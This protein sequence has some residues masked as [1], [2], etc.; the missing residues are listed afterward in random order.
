[1]ATGMSLHCLNLSKIHF[2]FRQGSSATIN[3]QTDLSTKLYWLTPSIIR[4]NNNLYGK[5]VIDSNS[6]VFG[7][8]VGF[9]S[10]I[11]SY[12]LSVFLYL[13]YPETLLFI[14][15]HM[16]KVN[17]K[18]LSFVYPLTFVLSKKKMV[19]NYYQYVHERQK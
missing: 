13:L 4:S 15:P 7:M 18:F 14:L 12:D 8:T 17:I 19:R 6:F 10:T 1:M 16:F 5:Q 9:N 3:R 11:G 2:E